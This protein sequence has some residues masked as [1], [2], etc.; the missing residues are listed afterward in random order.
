MLFNPFGTKTIT[1][2]EDIKKTLIRNTLQSNTNHVKNLITR[3]NINITN[4]AIVDEFGQN[5]L[6]ITSR[7]KNYELAKYLVSCNVDKN[8]KNIFGESSVDV[9]MK[10]HDREMLDILL[11]NDEMMRYKNENVRLINRV[12]D[13]ESNNKKLIETNKDLSIK[14]GLLR[15]QTNEALVSRK[16]KADDYDICF[17][18]NK[19]LK[20][21][22]TQLKSDNIAL[23]DTVKSLRNSMKK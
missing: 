1:V 19:K 3:N 7:T 11:N 10:N 18:E 4:N 6:H 16:R 14:N 8:K 2:E 12:D 9:A 13:L 22:I 20:S 21:D 5:L 23:Q 15:V 17:T